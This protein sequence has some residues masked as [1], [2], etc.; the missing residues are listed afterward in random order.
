MTRQQTQEQDEL[1]AIL[2]EM[3]TEEG[4]IQISRF[5]R[6]RKRRGHDTRGDEENEG[7]SFERWVE[8]RKRKAGRR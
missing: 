6:T 7:S 1:A 8:T 2:E 5:N 3:E 4:A